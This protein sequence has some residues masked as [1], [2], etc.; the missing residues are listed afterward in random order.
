MRKLI[1]SALVALLLVA[2]AAGAPASLARTSLDAQL[3]GT[4]DPTSTS[5]FR[6]AST[7]AV[8]S[9]RDHLALNPIFGARRST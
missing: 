9:T 5:C 2:S 8:T 3:A 1:L 4:C 7:I 6:L